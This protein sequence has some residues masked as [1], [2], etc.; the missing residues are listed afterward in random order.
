[1]KGKLLILI[2]L[3]AVVPAF[4]Q[5]AKTTAKPAAA[6]VAVKPASSALTDVHLFQSFFH[7]AP[8]AKSPFVQPT[9]GYANSSTT[10]MKEKYSTSTID[11][12]AM[13]GLPIQ[14]KFDIGGELYYENTKPNKGDGVSGL[15]DLGVYGKYNFKKDKKQIFSGGAM[16]TL[17]IGKEELG[18]SAM[19]FGFFGAFRTLLT[20]GM[21][22]TANAGLDFIEVP[23]ASDSFDADDFFAKA[24]KA[25]AGSSDTEHKT[26]F[27][28][29]GG[30]IYPLN[31]QTS[32]VGELLMRTEFDY[33]ML[34]GGVDHVL[35]N[36]GRI[37]GALGLG[38][39]DGA[40]DFMIQAGYFIN[41]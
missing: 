38:L 29:G 34:S 32:I 21:V 23:K 9:F 7:D 14:D 16:L 25:S 41:L 5:K 11:I 6:K 26:S 22:I 4:A 18:Y 3:I 31:R 28:I 12:G 17:P 10:I 39:D 2:A 30:L 37:R 19:N 15:T 40:P 20:N 35:K 8:L 27:R 1:M 24:A 33:M 13:G 36:G